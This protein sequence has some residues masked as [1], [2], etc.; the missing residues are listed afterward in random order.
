MSDSVTV[1]SGV[2]DPDALLAESGVRYLGQIDGVH[3]VVAG[4]G[5]A[6]QAILN[7]ADRRPA[8]RNAAKKAARRHLRERLGLIAEDD[9]AVAAGLALALITNRR[10]R[11][12]SLTADMLTI[13]TM[14]VNLLQDKLAPLKKLLDI[15]ARIDGMSDARAIYDLAARPE[16]APEWSA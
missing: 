2:V 10:A 16:D 1:P 6:A 5:A 8:Y 14:A 4:Q 3:R 15:E 12:Q 9:Q 13:E 7:A 11:S